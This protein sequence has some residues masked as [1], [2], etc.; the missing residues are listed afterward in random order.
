VNQDFLD[1][2]L[3]GVVIALITAALIWYF[4]QKNPTH[5]KNGIKGPS[6][7]AP[8]HARNYMPL[9]EGLTA[10]PGTPVGNNCCNIGFISS[11]CAI[12]L[13]SDYLSCDAGYVPA[14]T[15]INLGVSTKTPCCGG[16]IH[17]AEVSTTF[18]LGTRSRL[19]TLPKKIRVRQQI[20]CNP[21]VDATVPSAEVI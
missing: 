16:V 21:N 19:S 9:A 18:P 12:P 14:I 11:N 4:T 20:T 7:T 13:A 2:V 15:D 8:N 5:A 6:A 1:G 3:Q 10:A 17:R